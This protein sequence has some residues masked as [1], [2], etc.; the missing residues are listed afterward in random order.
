MIYEFFSD[1]T[2]GLLT[3]SLTNLAKMPNL[4]LIEYRILEYHTLKHNEKSVKRF[5][6]GYEGNTFNFYLSESDTIGFDFSDNRMHYTIEFKSFRI[7][8][9]GNST[10][11]DKVDD[12]KKYLISTVRN[13]KINQVI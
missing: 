7:S 2:L 11:N 5:V 8:H 6:F 12:V 1:K 10:N 3:N 4:K 13:Y 9:S